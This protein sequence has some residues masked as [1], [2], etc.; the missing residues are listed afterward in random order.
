MSRNFQ[1]VKERVNIV[2]AAKD[3]GLEVDRRKKAH[4]PFHDDRTPSLSFKGT[5]FTC[6]GIGCGKT[7]DVIDL[8]QHQAG[9]A[10]P[11]D[12]VR[13]LNSYYH[14]GLDIDGPVD[15][16]A[17]RKHR[18]EVEREQNRKRLFEEWE[19][20][21]HQILTSYFHFLRDC[22]EL[23]KPNYPFE[24]LHPLFVESLTKLDYIEYILDV[25]YI[26]GS[27]EEKLKFFSTEATFIRAIEQRLIQ[28]RIPYAGRN[29]W[30]DQPAAAFRPVIVGD[31]QLREAA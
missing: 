14:L 24:P 4:C 13:L 16:E 31:P 28:E 6:F 19:R 5:Q 23:Y 18:Q 30:G 1:L 21:S 27:D 26:Q 3:F 25:V 2:R 22:R 15:Y 29:E 7:G 9:L 17:I 11:L 20:I 12:A 10:T 8:V